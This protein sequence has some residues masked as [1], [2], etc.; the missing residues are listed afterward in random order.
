MDHLYY[1]QLINMVQSVTEVY[2]RQTNQAT[3]RGHVQMGKLKYEEILLTLL[4]A[5]NLDF[6]MQVLISLKTFFTSPSS[7]DFRAFLPPM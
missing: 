6:F 7:L 1:T 3:A 2:M 4:E 5:W